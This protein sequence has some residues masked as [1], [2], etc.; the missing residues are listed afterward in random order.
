VQQGECLSSIARKHGYASWR[1]IYYHPDNADFRR[2]RPD[3]NVI[4]PNDLLILPDVEIKHV[5]R[6]TDQRHRFVKTSV[7]TRL[8]ILV[9]D[10]DNQPLAS[11]RYELQVGTAR[12]VGTTGSDGIIEHTIVADEE[13]G[14]LELWI[15]E[16]PAED[17][18]KWEL[19]IG[20]LDP[21]GEITGVQARLNNLGFD[22]GPV[23]G[24]LGSKTRAA[25]KA[26]QKSTGLNI[27]G[28]PGPQTKDRL[29]EAHGS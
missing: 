3:P 24:I 7:K 23:D 1:T 26:F 2:N 21:V 22:C 12:H 9:R 6:P 19:R 29:K 5:S 25:T 17:S 27:D 28:I 10:E 14:S 16:A 15:S 20:H 13:S 18:R 8:R 4:Y 11:K